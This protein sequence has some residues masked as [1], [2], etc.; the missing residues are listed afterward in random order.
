[1]NR[2]MN[3]QKIKEILVKQNE[4]FKHLNLKHQQ[5]EQRL[6]E[7]NNREFKTEGEWIEV[8]NLKKHKLRIKDS[9]QRYIFEYR[10]NR[11]QC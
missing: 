9:M 10:Q 1:M 11:T 5:F 2:T 3:D 6:S 4:H 8:R 7:L